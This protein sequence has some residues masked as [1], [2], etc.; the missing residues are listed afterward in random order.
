M[1]VGP[2]PP[3]GEDQFLIDMQLRSSFARDPE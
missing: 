1:V 2:L 3:L